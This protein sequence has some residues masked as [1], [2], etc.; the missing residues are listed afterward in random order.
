MRGVL[1]YNY[2]NHVSVQMHV[3]AEWVLM[4]KQLVAISIS[5][6][7]ATFPEFL[8]VGVLR[9]EAFC[10]P[11]DFLGGGLLPLATLARD[12]TARGNPGL[13]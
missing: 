11:A 4:L 8:R 10:I 3:L 7:W 5:C 2:C 12:S 9:N 1:V 6:D 13:H